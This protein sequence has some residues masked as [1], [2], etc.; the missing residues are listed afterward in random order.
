MNRPN[1]PNRPGR[2]ARPN[3]LL[4]TVGLCVLLGACAQFKNPDEGSAEVEHPTSSTPAQVVSC[5]K[6]K[7]Q[8]HELP[9]TV[10][11]LPQGAMLDF[12]DSNI[13]KVRTDNGQ[14]LYR[15][16]PGKRHVKTLWLDTAGADCAPA[17]GAS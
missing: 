10:S 16:Y 1:Q 9:V 4:S 8:K 12:G 2:A 13:V 15:F 3:I 5:L 11:A 6:D 17:S 7:A 14:T